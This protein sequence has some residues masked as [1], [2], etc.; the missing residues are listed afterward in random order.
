M[1]GKRFLLHHI[2]P[3][4]FSLLILY[5]VC[6]S[7]LKGDFLSWDKMAPSGQ[8]PKFR[9]F[10]NSNGD[11]D[12]EWAFRSALHSGDHII[13]IGS[14]EMANTNSKAIPFNFLTEHQVPCLGVGH[15]GN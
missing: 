2:L 15:E 13:V 4:L 14:S 5:L 6:G 10:V 11:M 8:A 9:S 7:S 3:F 12:K 1:H